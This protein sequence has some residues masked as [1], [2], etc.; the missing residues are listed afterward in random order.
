MD[1]TEDTYVDYVDGQAV[2]DTNTYN[3]LNYDLNEYLRGGRFEPG[4]EQAS[5]LLHNA[6]SRLPE[7]PENVPLLR[8]ADVDA[9]YGNRFK[10]GDYMTNGRLFMSASSKN[11][12]AVKSVEQG[13]AAEGQTGGMAIYE[14]HAKTARPMLPGITT[15][16]GHEA[17]SVALPNTVYRLEA[18]INSTRDTQSAKAL[19]ITAMRLIEVPVTESMIVKNIHTGEAVAIGPEEQRRPPPL[20]A[21]GDASPGSS[22]EYY[23]WSGSDS[24]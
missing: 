6:L 8:V 12:Y 15:L 9:S 21:A 13:Y 24:D 18:I 11:D 3:E 7:L 10:V 5:A 20:P 17:E 1:G 23:Y 16:A 4:F 2:A 22:P 19:P 14:I